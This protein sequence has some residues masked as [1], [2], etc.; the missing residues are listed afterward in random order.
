MPCARLAP[1]VDCC[2]AVLQVLD[3]GRGAERDARLL[4][5][6][7]DRV[8]GVAQ[9]G[10]GRATPHLSDV[11]QVRDACRS[12]TRSCIQCVHVHTCVC[13]HLQERMHEAL[14]AVATV[15]DGSCLD[16]LQI[17]TLLVKV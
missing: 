17:Q 8:V 14:C 4:E 6:A 11:Q 1:A 2:A 3:A 13:A 16:R 15:I 10:K 5:E 12:P 7:V 9:D